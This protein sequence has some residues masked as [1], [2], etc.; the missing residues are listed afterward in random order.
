MVLGLSNSLPTFNVKQLLETACF[1]IDDLV[2]CL[3]CL[4]SQV[5]FGETVF[6]VLE[7]TKKQTVGE[8]EFT[9]K[10]INYI[11]LIGHVVI[12]LLDVLSCFVY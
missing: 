11:N 3:G 10:Y 1:V 2:C 5:K 6:C 7:E 9:S 12:S 4:A 8:E